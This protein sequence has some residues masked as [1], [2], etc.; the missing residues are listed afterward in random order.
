MSEQPPASHATAGPGSYAPPAGYAPGWYPPPAPRTSGQSVAVLVLGI[1]SLTVFWGLAGIVALVLAPGAKRQIAASGGTLGGEGLIRAG[2][3]CSW[4]SIVL[5]A[6]AIVLI[7]GLLVAV[8]A[9]G[10]G[11]D[12]YIGTEVAELGTR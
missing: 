2:V 7:V 5:T 3:I 10:S 6:I 9:G 4:I 12:T 11:V 1:A 8:G